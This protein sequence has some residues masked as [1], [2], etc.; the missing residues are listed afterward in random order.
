MIS[1][2]PLAIAIALL[3]FALGAADGHAQFRGSQ[4][5]IFGGSRGASRDHQRDGQESRNS[6][7][8]QVDDDSYEQVEYRLSLLE[9]DLHPQAEQRATWERFAA[10]VH[11][12][13]SDLARA[14]ARATMHPADAANG[15]SGIRAIEQAADAARNRA[16]A[17]DDIAAAAKALYAMLTPD[18]K[19]LCDQRIGTIV[20]P[21]THSLA[22]AGSGT[23]LPDLGSSARPQR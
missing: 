12:Y 17:L 3:A 7:R 6:R 10:T 1:G 11:A 22:G 8:P 15:G 14:R 16:T 13:A 4:G 19:T 23:N 21:P 20:A 5:G 18:Q 9:E 2:K